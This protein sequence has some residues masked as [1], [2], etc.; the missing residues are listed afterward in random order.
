MQPIVD[1]S[2]CI[3]WTRA[4]LF[5]TILDTKQIRQMKNLVFFLVASSMISCGI[6]KYQVP[7]H[8]LLPKV[9]ASDFKDSLVSLG[10]DTILGYWDAC[11]G[12]VQG[13]ENP[14]YLY[15]IYK[16]EICLTKFTETSNYNILSNQW[17]PIDFV[18]TYFDEII[19]D[20][21]IEPDFGLLHYDFEEVHI[22]LAEREFHLRIDEYEKTVNQDNFKVRLIDKIRS[23]LF[24][25]DQWKWVG[26]NF[27]LE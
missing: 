6:G 23:D 19:A 11:S 25:V 24:E 21:I 15:W 8:H 12:C 2:F 17:F 13:I 9:E 4:S 1:D 16:G 27:K 3:N 10:V 26:Q 20:S 18:C 14:Y 7:V 5:Q 22:K